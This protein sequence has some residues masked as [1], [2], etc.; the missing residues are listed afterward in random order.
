MSRKEVI[1]GVILFVLFLWIVKGFGYRSIDLK[2][3]L[4]AHTVNGLTKGDFGV[5]DEEPK[6]I[7]EIQTIDGVRQDSKFWLEER[8]PIPDKGATVKKFEFDKTGA[9]TEKYGVSIGDEVPS[10]N[11]TSP[12]VY[13][14]KDFT[15]SC[16]YLTS[17]DLY[18]F[19]L[20]RFTE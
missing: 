15:A 12:G 18:K 1:N 11:R 10:F 16:Y 8:C 19:A 4:D 7:I 6:M 3:D 14:T 20:I 13:E 9:L 2:R 5:L 17:A